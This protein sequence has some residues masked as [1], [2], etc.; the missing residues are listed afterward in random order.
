MRMRNIFIVTIFAGT[1]GAAATTSAD[2]F[3]IVFCFA[4]WALIAC[5]IM[6]LARFSRSDEI[7]EQPISKI[8][9]ID[10]WVDQDGVHHFPG[11]VFDIENNP[12][13]GAHGHW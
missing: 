8:E 2:P 6:L 12:R 4:F 11:D 1:V 9:E 13:P 10:P 3:V 7:D 5:A